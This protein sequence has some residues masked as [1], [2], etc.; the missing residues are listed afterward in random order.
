V[1]RMSD[2]VHGYSAREAERLADQASILRDRIHAGI[3]YPPGSRVLEVGS[4]TGLQTEALLDASPGIHVTCLDIDAG[5]LARAR[6]RLGERAARV[7]FRTG[8]LLQPAAVEDGAHDHAF[9]CFVLE[10]LARPVD[11]LTAVRRAL[12]PGGTLVVTEGDHGSAY[13]HPETHAARAVWSAL[14]EQQRRLGGDPCIGRR[15]HGLVAAAG[16]DDVQVSPWMVYADAGTP[17]LR[18]GFVRRIIAPMV[19][20]VRAGA[21]DAGRV[22]AATWQR[23]LAELEAIAD[24]VDGAFCYT[25]FR[26]TARA[27]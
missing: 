3:A 9:V 8:D 25:F 24:G 6:T 21:I 4:G 10:H 19:D 15:L 11:A 5:Q 12:R 20:G 7:S 1:P 13:F 18:D 23:G 26:A 22:D 16:F 2:Y 17:A 27:T 14:I